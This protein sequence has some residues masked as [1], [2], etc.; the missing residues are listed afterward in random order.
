MRDRKYALVVFYLLLFVSLDKVVK[1]RRRN[2]I[3]HSTVQNRM[4]VASKEHHINEEGEA[5]AEKVARDQAD[6][7]RR[8]A[9]VAVGWSKSVGSNSIR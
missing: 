5:D 4:A 7:E 3:K 8:G 9:G 1:Y 6:E 2:R